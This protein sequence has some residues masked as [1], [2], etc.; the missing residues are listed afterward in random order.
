MK[1]L[2]MEKLS[3]LLEWIKDA[4]TISETG[5]FEAQL[6]EELPYPEFLKLAEENRRD[7]QRRTDAGDETATLTFTKPAPAKATPPAT[8]PATI[9]SKPGSAIRPT[10]QGSVAGVK[11]PLVGSAAPAAS[12]ARIGAGYGPSSPYGA[13]SAAYGAIMPSM[14]PYGA[15]GGGYYGGASIYRRA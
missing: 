6:D 12:R 9:G 2:G 10:A 1:M 8:K 14:P 13:P 5:Y 3:E 7:R 4:V 15:P 11:R